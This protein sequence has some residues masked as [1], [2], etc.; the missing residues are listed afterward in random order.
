MVFY[1]STNI[2][3]FASLVFP[4]LNEASHFYF[5]LSPANNVVSHISHLILCQISK[6]YGVIYRFLLSAFQTAHMKS[7]TF[8]RQRGSKIISFELPR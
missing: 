6:K 3:L 7:D 1:F 8:I 4:F 2:M 5:A